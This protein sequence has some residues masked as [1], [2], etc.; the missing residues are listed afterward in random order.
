MPVDCPGELQWHITRSPSR[1]EA[2]FADFSIQE[3][4]AEV[5]YS[6]DGKT[7]IP[8]ALPAMRLGVHIESNQPGSIWL[9]S[10]TALAST[11]RASP[12]C[13]PSN[14]DITWLLALQTISEASD[15][16]IRADPQKIKQWTVQLE[17]EFAL[18]TSPLR[19][20]YIS[21]VLANQHWLLADLDT[22]MQWFAKALLLWRQLNRSELYY[23]ALLGKL[24][25]TSRKQ[26]PITARDFP[27][28]ADLKFS[29]SKFYA[30]R[31]EEIRCFMLRHQGA[32]DQTRACFAELAETYRAIDE[33]FEAVNSWINL[34]YLLSETELSRV[35]LA[36]MSST[37]QQLPESAAANIY[38]AKYFLTLHYLYQHQGDFYAAIQANL[39][40]QQYFRNST[41]EAQIWLVSAKRQLAGTYLK[42]GLHEQALLLLKET[43]EQ[44]DAKVY[45]ARAL[46]VLDSLS[47][48]FAEAG[49]LP[50]AIE[51]QE[52]ALELREKLVLVSDQ[53]VS[54]QRLQRLDPSRP[55]YRLYDPVLPKAQLIEERLLE[56]ELLILSGKL[57]EAASK[58][59][60]MAKEKLSDPIL[61]RLA[62]ITAR[63]KSSQGE[64]TD[65]N[66]LLVARLQVN[67][68]LLAQQSSSALAY[69]ALHQ[70]RDFSRMWVDAQSV[71]GLS[72]AD[73]ATRKISQS[74]ASPLTPVAI[75]QL[76]ML[77]NPIR[78]LT[79]PR[80][81]APVTIADAPIK[82]LAHW[83]EGAQTASRASALRYPELGKLQSQLPGDVAIF[84]LLPGE[85]HSLGLWVF[86]A[87]TEIIILPA[88][89]QL[90]AQIAR[91]NNWIIRKGAFGDWKKL[92]VPFEGWWPKAVPR[93]LWVVADE[94]TLSVP[95]AA[96]REDGLE[97]LEIS[98]L[99]GLRSDAA[100]AGTPPS[101]A[102]QA[103]RQTSLAEQAT[104]QKRTLRFFAPDDSKAALASRLDF[105]ERELQ[106]LSQLDPIKFVGEAANK[107]NFVTALQSSDWTHVAAHGAANVQ[108]F[109]LA[110]FWLSRGAKASEGSFVSWLELSQLINNNELLVLNACD[111]ASSAELGRQASVSFALAASSAGAKHTIAALWPVSDTASATWI[112]SFYTAL[113]GDA[114]RSAE[115]LRTAQLKLSRSPHFRHPYHWASLVH[116]RQFNFKP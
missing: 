105:A 14:A 74:N 114:N 82:G 52:R 28:A 42:L 30:A 92:R 36:R 70:L 34:I 12:I 51:W 46:A 106:L 33:P 93:K 90:K 57:T 113:Q 17:R 48:A 3:S 104:R 45:P 59:G 83:I 54:R 97:L 38:R 60:A 26:R 87:R 76:A 61:D 98:Y 94:L 35:N 112:P 72:L 81:S 16:S 8:I 2:P 20:A 85:R 4:G 25:L 31:F 18:A 65:S 39:K 41:E 103:T 95:F 50:E 115:A 47:Q 29:G 32:V 91:L 9:K 80:A 6:K 64:V 10:S 43:L 69:L 53:A 15:F 108:E 62:L 79:P 44:V 66:K 40:A 109:G 77:Q 88:E 101:L 55:G 24:D 19:R 49:R 5:E 75:W 84:V 116:F 71:D 111:L 100:H 68:Q 7:W 96:L 27:A 107:K 23:A 99:T 21:H 78:Q 89:A 11:V 110:G 22:S 56:I 1:F 37:L 58:V 67:A 86:G 102:A 63:I 13:D 73:Q